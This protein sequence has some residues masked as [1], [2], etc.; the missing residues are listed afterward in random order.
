[1]LVRTLGF[2]ILRGWRDMLPLL[3]ALRDSRVPASARLL[4]LAALGYLLSP[5]DAVP[6]V[7]PMAGLID[8]MI[9]APLG[10]AAAGR[11]LPQHLRREH[12]AQADHV[13]KRAR[14][15]LLGAALVF[16]AF[17]ALLII[18]FWMLIT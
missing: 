10:L 8:D 14:W 6:D 5:V 16:I 3:L 2:R 15:L 18:G 1:M 13:A 11:M 12:E 7:L 4:T 9:I 17:W